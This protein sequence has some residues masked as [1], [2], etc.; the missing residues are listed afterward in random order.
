MLKNITYNMNLLKIFYYIITVIATI[1]CLP[2]II[3]AIFGFTRMSFDIIPVII[4]ISI[5]LFAPIPLITL[6]HS[7]FIKNKSEKFQKIYYIVFIIINW[8][9][10]MAYVILIYL[11]TRSMF[12]MS[13]L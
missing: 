12:N 2:I 9:L 7:F 11:S 4:L 3:F 10:I 8:I 6:I 13:I 5:F 1:F